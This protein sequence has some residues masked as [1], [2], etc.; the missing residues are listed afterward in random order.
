[1]SDILTAKYIAVGSPTLNNNMLPTVSGF[2]TYLKGLSPKQRI[3]FA[4]GSYGWG[5]QSVAQVEQSLQDCGFDKLCDSVR[6]QYIP[7]KADLDALAAQVREGIH[8]CQ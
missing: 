6:I 7:S 1:M 2:L 8:A 5:G 4:F 3:S